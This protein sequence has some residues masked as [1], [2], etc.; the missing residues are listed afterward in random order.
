MK[1]YRDE[2]CI[3]C[4]HKF[5]D[6]EGIIPSSHGLYCCICAEEFNVKNVNEDSQDR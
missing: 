3:C 5:D 4:G 6:Y 1:S 2:K